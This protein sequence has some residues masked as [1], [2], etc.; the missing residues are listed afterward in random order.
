MVDNVAPLRVS[1]IRSKWGWFVG[2]GV[3]LLVLGGIAFGNLLLATVAS[4]YFI[5]SLMLIGGILHLV[6]AFQVKGWE[7]ILF[8]ALSGLL[9]TL[10]GI[11]AFINPLL[12]SAALTLLMAVALLAAGIFRIWVGVKFRPEKGWG[13]IVAGGVVSVLAA[14][15]IALG[16]PV[17]SLWILGLFLAIDLLI[18]GW[19]SIAFGLAIRK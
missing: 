2:L 11:S 10:A 16:W 9:Y 13:W 8:W 19:A 14:L 1:E 18:Q 15:V 17:N 5:G 12:A 7:N 4:I 3:L 6:Q